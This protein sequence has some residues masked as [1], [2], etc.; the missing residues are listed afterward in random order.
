M[1]GDEEDGEAFGL[2][3]VRS[4]PYEKV[5]KRTCEV[6]MTRSQRPAMLTDTNSNLVE[7]TSQLRENAFDG[8]VCFS[9]LRWDFVYQRPQHI[10]SRLAR[11]YPVWFVEEPVDATDERA[12]LDIRSESSG[13]NVVTPCLAA[14]TP[15]ERD[16]EEK[17]LIDQLILSTGLSRYLLWFYTPMA[18]ACAPS[19]PPM[20]TVYDCMDELSAFK[21]APASLELAERALLAKSTV[22]FAGGQSL[23]DAKRRHHRR[24]HLFPSSV[25]IPHFRR[26]RESLP[27]PDIQ[28]AIPHPRVGFFGVVDERFDADLLREAAAARPHIHFVV[29]GPV[30]KIDSAGLPRRSNIHYLGKQA[31]GDLPAFLA[32]WDIAMMPFALNASTRFIS[33]TKTPEYLAGGRLVVSTSIRDVVDRYGSSGAVKI[34]RASGDET[35]LLS[36]V[37]ALDETLE[38]SAD[39]LA[40]QQAADEALSGMSW[41]DTF[42]RMHDVIMQALD[43]RREAIHAR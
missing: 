32:H 31:Y 37:G 10:V 25:D 4:R 19:L 38:R 35:S 41:D 28:R 36:F 42:E 43:Q 3:M 6:I 13:L 7:R 18:L 39:R 23:Y 1:P 22:V 8:V 2:L 30:V 12:R 17:R 5:G 27:E 16:A 26:A 15:L 11:R 33:P 9:H 21:G 24:V 34:A 29:L 20:A 14:G 40:V